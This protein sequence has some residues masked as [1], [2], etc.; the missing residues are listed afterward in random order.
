ML[1]YVIIMHADHAA[2]R[3]RVL[4]ARDLAMEDSASE[5]SGHSDTLIKSFEV[6]ADIK[7]KMFFI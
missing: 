7:D 5:S 3:G 4:L 1:T 6:H 2:D